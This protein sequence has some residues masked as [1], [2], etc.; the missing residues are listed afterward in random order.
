MFDPETIRWDSESSLMDPLLRMVN[1]N[2]FA[3]A[4]SD[5][6]G[7]WTSDFSGVQQLY[8]VYT[9]QYAGMNINQSKE[10]FQFGSGNTYS[11]KLLAVNGM[12]GS[13]RYAEVKSSGKFTVPNNWQVSFSKI[14]NRARRYH[15]YFKCI[16]GARI[17]MMLD[18]DVPGNGMYTG[19]GRK[20]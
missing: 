12:V 9:G 18:A 19:F 8:H 17:L 15:A 14:E 5:F 20:E 11:W 7:T 2:K 16:K 13:M 1:Y 3:V 10:T 6:K 4:A